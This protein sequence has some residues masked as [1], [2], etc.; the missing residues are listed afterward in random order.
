MNENREAYF[1]VHEELKEAL[2]KELVDDIDR[3]I[4]REL[5]LSQTPGLHQTPPEE[6]P[7]LEWE[8]IAPT[9]EEY[10]KAV[11]QHRKRIFGEDVDGNPEDAYDESMKGL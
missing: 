9:E 1:N 10:K 11:E 4:M 7:E 2:S 8:K 3:M 5:E 6:L